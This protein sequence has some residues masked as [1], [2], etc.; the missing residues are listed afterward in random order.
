MAAVG[1]GCFVVGA[2]I[3]LLVAC[4]VNKSRRI[5]RRKPFSD[6][7]EDIDAFHDDDNVL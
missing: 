3:G 4:V 6:D 7:E 1:V 2:G 5:K